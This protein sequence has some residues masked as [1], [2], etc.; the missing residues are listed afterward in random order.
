M[1][2]WI[3]GGSGGEIHGYMDGGEGHSQST[4]AACFPVL[5]AWSIVFYFFLSLRATI[6]ELV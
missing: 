3:G 6:C 2:E 1:D 5:E 4:I